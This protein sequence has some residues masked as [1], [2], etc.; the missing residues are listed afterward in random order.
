MRLQAPE[1]GKHPAILHFA[2]GFLPISSALHF[3]DDA[4][5][6]E[7]V[8][9][10]QRLSLRPAEFRRGAGFEKVFDQIRRHFGVVLVVNLIVDTLD[11][12][13]VFQLEKWTG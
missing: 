5:V 11:N 12:F 9:I 2:P 1:L 8:Q 10:G 3:I 4:R 7:L 6:N 13:G